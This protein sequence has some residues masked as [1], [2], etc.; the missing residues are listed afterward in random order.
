MGGGPSAHP[1]TLCSSPKVFGR[2]TRGGQDS[3]RLPPSGA[4]AEVVESCDSDGVLRSKYINPRSL[5]PFTDLSKLSPSELAR[6]LA[7][8][9]MDMTLPPLRVATV[10]DVLRQ[11]GVAARDCAVVPIRCCGTYKARPLRKSSLASSSDGVL[12]SQHIN[13]RSLI[14]FA[15]LSLLSP[16]ELARHLACVVMDD[17]PPPSVSQRLG[18]V[19]RM[20]PASSALSN[21]IATARMTRRGRG[22]RLERVTPKHSKCMVIR[23]SL[24]YSFSV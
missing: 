4:A 17:D 6:H 11:F 10:G 22:L 20:P 1:P 8:A 18:L 2:G 9:A 21:Q 5:V 15:E 12:R 3:G 14:P 16:S 19:S 24:F 23:S 7:G 13:S